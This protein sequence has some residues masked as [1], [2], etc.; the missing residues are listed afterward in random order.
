[1]KSVAA[2]WTS[3][4]TD[5]TNNSG[6]AGLPGGYRS[7]GG[8]YTMRGYYEYGWTSTQGD[9]TDFS[10]SRSLTYDSP[11]VVRSYLEKKSGFNVRC[12]RDE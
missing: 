6:F 2:F 8:E 11:Q 5:A 7:S 9:Y 4:N 12:L 1:M 3:P 10:W